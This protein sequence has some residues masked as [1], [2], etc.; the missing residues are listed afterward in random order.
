M[1]RRSDAWMNATQILKVANFDKPQRTRI[2]EREVQKGVHEKIQGGYGKY[3]GTWVPLERGRE[4]ANQYNVEELLRPV[5]DYQPTATSPPP[6]PKHITASSIRGRLHKG[7]GALPRSALGSKRAAAVAAAAAAAGRAVTTATRG[8]RG[9]GR[10]RKR[11]GRGSRSSR[12]IDDDDE[13]EEEEDDDEDDDDDDEHDTF[14]KESVQNGTED[15]DMENDEIEASPVHHQFSYRQ[16]VQLRVDDESATPDSGSISSGSSILDSGSEDTDAN[17]ADEEHVRGGRSR[18]HHL[19]D[20]LDAAHSHAHISEA[21]IKYSNDLLDYFVAP[22]DDNIPGFLI[23]KPA[24]F[25]VNAAIDDEGHTAFHWACAIGHFRMIDVLLRNGADITIVNNLGQTALIRAI[26]FTNNYERRTFPKVVDLLQ[27]T[28]FQLDRFGQTVLHH[29]ASTTTSKSKQ[30]AARY[31]MEIILGKVIET[32]NN[33]TLLQ[34]L[35]QQ[36]SNGDTALHIAIRNGSRKVTKAFSSYGAS[37][38]IQNKVGQTAQ[39]LMAA[40]SSGMN[41]TP[42]HK[43]SSSPYQVVDHHHVHYHH[44]TNGHGPHGV[45]TPTSTPRERQVLNEERPLSRSATTPN[46]LL[47]TPRPHVSEAAIEATQKVVPAMAEHLE[48]LATAYDAELHD[49]EGDLAQ[50]TQLLETMQKDIRTSESTVRELKAEYDAIDNSVVDATDS[51]ERLMNIAETLARKAKARVDARA[52]DLRRL[53]EHRQSQELLTLAREE[54]MK[55]IKPDPESETSLSND[56]GLQEKLAKE[57]F[58]LQLERKGMISEIVELWAGAGVGEKMNDY[59]RLI[60]LSCGV[61]VEEI[62]DLLDGIAQALGE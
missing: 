20:A 12:N 23:H 32:Q 4:I 1:R 2:L 8:A 38:Q 22:D 49:K 28:I 30:S 60:S 48:A 44:A 43:S 3:Q 53:V 21:Q 10:A 58:A 9:R 11:G 26:T 57:L 14:D 5:F 16:P 7:G 13:P 39:T 37:T 6:A 35:N 25:D 55:L 59:R 42:G 46:G 29:I 31:Y 40:S 36:D 17:S 33:E 54:E 34:F 47:I 41:G 50:A 15:I 19:E 24:D 62:D 45:T 56:V 27:S 18:K 51:D 52:K 61:R